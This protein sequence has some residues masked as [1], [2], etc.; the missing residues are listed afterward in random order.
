M[1]LTPEQIEIRRKV[2]VSSID[3]A[4]YDSIRDRVN[5]STLKLMAKSPAHYRER[6]QNP[7]G[8]DS[9]AMRLGRAT[10]LAVLEPDKFRS[11][12]VQWTEGRR[13]GKAWEAFA[14]EHAHHEILTPPE[15]ETCLAIQRAVR[16]SD[17]ASRY[18]LKGS[19]E[20]TVLWEQT[21]VTE[22]FPE[23]RHRCKG[24]LDWIAPDALVDLKT[25]RDASPEAFGRSCFNFSYHAQAAFYSDGYEMATGYQL[26]FV[27]V[28]VETSAPFT[29]QAYRVPEEVIDMG[30]ELYWSWLD[31][32]DLCRRENRWPGYGDGELPLTLPHW[33]MKRD[34]DLSELGLTFGETA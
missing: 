14:A 6:I 25:T 34:D 29:V 1:S 17:S 18:L 21:S 7:P 2:G 12:V 10:H 23:A 20:Q 30:R 32:L 5:F 15:W 19:A 9:D 33:A 24:R 27:V 26:P 3:R 16:A 13:A 4:A 22:G 28:A 8:P 31:R 11:E